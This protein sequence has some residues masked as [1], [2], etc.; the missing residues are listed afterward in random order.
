MT[1]ILVVCA[2][3]ATLAFTALAAQ[4]IVTLRQVRHTAKAVEYLALNA[5]EKLTAL[6]SVA[7][8]VQAV[9]GGISSGWLRA[10]QAIY[11]LFSKKNQE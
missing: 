4:A 2:V 7:D 9:A 8:A 5:D 10:A 11:G 1:T 6:D 3:I